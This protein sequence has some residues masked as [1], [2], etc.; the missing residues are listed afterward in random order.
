MK[1]SD[2]NYIIQ[3]FSEISAK[4]LINLKNSRQKLHF[5]QGF[6]Q[7]YSSYKLTKLTLIIQ[8]FVT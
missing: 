1:F 5:N 7:G 3:L 4:S 8:V 2:F 6:N